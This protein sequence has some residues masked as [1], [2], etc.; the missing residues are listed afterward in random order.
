MILRQRLFLDIIPDRN[1]NSI[2]SLIPTLLLI[3]GAPVM[4]IG[5]FLIENLGISSTAW[6]LG[7]VGVFSFFF[8]YVSLRMIPKEQ[9]AS[10]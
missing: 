7:T 10:F 5:G 1:R 6:I 3:T 8:Y 2:Y 9:L 4:I